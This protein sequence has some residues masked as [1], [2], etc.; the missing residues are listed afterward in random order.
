MNMMTAIKDILVYILLFTATFCEEGV[1]ILNE[2][3]S[4]VTKLEVI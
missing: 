4:L 2:T 1:V 3:A